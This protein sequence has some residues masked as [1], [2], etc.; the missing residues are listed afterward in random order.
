[1]TSHGDSQYVLDEVDSLARLEDL[2]GIRTSLSQK[3]AGKGQP[4]AGAT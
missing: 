3:E 1:M 4:L 2:D